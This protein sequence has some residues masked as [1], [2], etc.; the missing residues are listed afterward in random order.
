MVYSKPRLIPRAQQT[1]TGQASQPLPGM[2]INWFPQLTH[3]SAAIAD[4]LF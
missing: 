2:A 1:S 4:P 3:T